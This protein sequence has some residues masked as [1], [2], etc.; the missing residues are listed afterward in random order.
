M[1]SENS[2]ETVETLLSK[3]TTVFPLELPPSMDT[4]FRDPPR[5]DEEE[6]LV[7]EDFGGKLWTDVTNAGLFRNNF[8]LALLS[9]K[10][11]QYYIPA[12]IRAT[13]RQLSWNTDRSNWGRVDGDEIEIIV[14]TAINALVS[15]LFRPYRK[16]ISQN[17][18]KFINSFL[19]EFLPYA[20]EFFEKKPIILYLKKW[21][22]QG[23]Q[24]CQESKNKR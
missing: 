13:L 8:S 6:L 14:I 9:F 5:N 3:M 23:K 12:Y 19:K 4:L 22:N 18:Q 2:I 11:F 1:R 16:G 21:D 10:T 17:R 24:R 20:D 7:E 15:D